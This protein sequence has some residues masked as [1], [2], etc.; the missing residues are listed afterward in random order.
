MK[1][2]I[3]LLAAFTLMLVCSYGLS[4]EPESTEIRRLETELTDTRAELAEC[5]EKLT[6]AT[7]DLAVARFGPRE[8]Q[9]AK[10]GTDVPR[11]LLHSVGM[12][13]AGA[14]I[15]FVVVFSVLRF[16]DMLAKID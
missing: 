4:A 8:R 3:V 15:G 11:G 12:C 1:Q 2:A 5:Q 7:T 6:A 10:V 14:V 13:S 9:E 16:A